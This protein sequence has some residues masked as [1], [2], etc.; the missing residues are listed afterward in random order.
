MSLQF[1]SD[2]ETLPSQSHPAPVLSVCW[3]PSTSSS[4]SV[5]LSGDC[6]GNIRVFNAQ[7]ALSYRSLPKPHSN[8]V[9]C[10]TTNA[11]GT[12]ALSNAIDGTVALWSLSPFAKLQA[13][14]QADG[15]AVGAETA[16]NEPALLPLPV[17]D[18][19]QLL[20]GTIDSLASQSTPR[21][22]LSEAWKTALHPT[23]PLFASVGAGA[24]ISLH[25]LPT[26]HSSALGTLLSVAP[27]PSSLESKRDVFGLSLAFHPSGTL[28]AVGTNIGQTLLY[29]VSS[30]CS[31]E[32]LLT[33]V[34]S[35][36]D[37]PSPIRAVSFTQNLLLC[38][39]DDRTI[40]A[41]D[42]KP[43]LSPSQHSY[44]P[45][46]E[47]ERIGGSVASLAGHKG[48][49]LALDS[50]QGGEA[51]VFASIGADKSIKF[52]DLTSA[53]KSTPVWNGG[54]AHPIRAFAFQT[55][56][57]GQVTKSHSEDQHDSHAAA[58]AAATSSMTR[59][60]TASEDGKLRWYRGAGLG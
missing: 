41:H 49:V 1:L 10:I 28:L 20:V 35:Y 40:T 17:D 9:H 18:A 19:S 53:T 25:S 11:A 36:L 48:W 37:H 29:S 3:V 50:V 58:I 42:V 59:F 12:L 4:Q 32:P 46:G 56:S 31:H 47:V 16:S 34:S 52:W 21:A 44:Q 54:E 51:N 24:S 33:F 38:G 57:S 45:D 13:Q 27:L 60:V 14:D 55:T 7:S 2:K 8:A 22:K 26:N 39:S 30:P 43:I 6:Q 5:I 23:S 15:D